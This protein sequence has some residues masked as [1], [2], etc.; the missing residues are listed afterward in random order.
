MTLPY[1]VSFCIDL[2]VIII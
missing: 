2:Q 1:T